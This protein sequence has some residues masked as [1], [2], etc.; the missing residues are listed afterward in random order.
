MSAISYALG[1]VFHQVDREILQR[2]YMNASGCQAG[3]LQHRILATTIWGRVM[4]DINLVG[5]IEKLLCSE[6]G[7][8]IDTSIHGVVYHYADE[9]LRGHTIVSV[10]S[11]FPGVSC[12]NELG[13]LGTTCGCKGMAFPTQSQTALRSL[14]TLAN[15]LIQS[16]NIGGVQGY[17]RTR[18]VANNSILLEDTVAAR[19]TGTFKVMV[20]HDP[21]L[22]DIQPRYWIPFS[23]LVVS[24][25]KAYIYNSARSLIQRGSLYNGGDYSILADIASEFSDA[26][27][28]YKILRRNWGKISMMNDRKRYNRFISL[29]LP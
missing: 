9:Y 18:I 21:E 4:S 1:E 16:T 27:E 2:A 29:Q 15:T 28:N 25:V 22:N 13:A 11:W 19:S 6:H 20:T 26:E 7:Q 8:I 23:E 3:N 5:G 12:L 24:A 17:F 10:M 14:E